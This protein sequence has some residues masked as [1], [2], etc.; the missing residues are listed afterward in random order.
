MARKE[1]HFIVGI[2]IT[3]RV[4]NV[5]A[6]QDVLTQFGCN[7]KTRIGLH[8]TSDNFCSPNGLI[9]VELLGGNDIFDKF[10]TALTDISGVDLKEMVFTHDS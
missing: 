7:I 6:V 4:S 10:K 3:D 2:H 8:E 5:P 1:N 9:L